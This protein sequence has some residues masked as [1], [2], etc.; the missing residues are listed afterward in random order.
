MG[1]WTPTGVE[2]RAYDDDDDDLKCSVC[3]IIVHD[4]SESYVF[5]MFH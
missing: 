5:V 4:T 3:A 1:H 2:P